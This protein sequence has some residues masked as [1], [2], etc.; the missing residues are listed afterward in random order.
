MDKREASELQKSRVVVADK[1]PIFLYKL[2]QIY[3]SAGRRLESRYK[4][5]DSIIEAA[6]EGLILAQTI[7]FRLSQTEKAEVFIEDHIR[8]GWLFKGN[9]HGF[10]GCCGRHS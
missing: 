1:N 3:S 4:A 7:A 2:S 10:L 5:L 8:D 6:T 9:H